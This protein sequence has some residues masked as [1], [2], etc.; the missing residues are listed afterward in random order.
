[1][2]KAFG[3]Y[4]HY[5][6]A[7]NIQAKEFEDCVTI[8][9]SS[10]SLIDD[11]VFVIWK[12]LWTEDE[13]DETM[14]DSDKDNGSIIVIPETLL[15]SEDDSDMDADSDSDM[16]VTETAGDTRHTVTFK[17]IGCTREQN[18]QEVLARVAQVRRE[19]GNVEVRIEPEPTNPVDAKAIAFQCKLNNVWSTIGYVVSEVLDEVHQA[20]STNSITDVE[21]EWVKF[22]IMWRTP[23]WYAGINLTRRGEW[24]RNVLTSQSSKI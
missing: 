4:W 7:Y 8:D 19:G 20:L 11:E 24:S 2:P 17:C 13:Q 12:W 10:L 6:I 14:S 23:G 15:N 18:Y 1:M 9:V 22:A 21:F 16:P 3:R 5:L